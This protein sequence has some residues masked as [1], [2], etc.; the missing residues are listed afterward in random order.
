[1][2]PVMARGRSY[3][4]TTR[5]KKGRKG[6]TVK[7]RY[8]ISVPTP[9]MTGVEIR[10]PSLP[11]WHLS[12]KIL[13]F[14][15]AAGLAILLY[16]LLTHPLFQVQA[17]EVEGLLRLTPEEVSHSLD[18]A[19][20]PVFRLDP[21]QMKAALEEDYPE[22]RD[23]SILIGLPAQ[24]V[25][26][27][28]ER[29]PLIAWNQGEQ[30]TWVDGEGYAFSPRG[31]AGNL[32]VVNASGTP[33]VPEPLQAL[34]EESTEVLPETLAENAPEERV[35]MTP[36]FVNAVLL[37][38]AQ[39]PEKVDLAFDPVHGFGW[40]DARGWQVFFGLDVSQMDTKLRVYK[41]IVKKVKAEGITP[42]LIS[43]EHV[44]APYY[45]M[46]R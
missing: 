11:V 45:R 38:R 43:I 34:P 14:S 35:F 32:V 26:Q 6:K 8:D 3:P 40:Q 5:A 27:V 36:E 37:M 23:I 4:P 19:N 15:L 17:V 42:A 28:T 41:S 44:H 22:L 25:I 39:A 1:M 13:S 10:L 31:E 29:V 2:P 21:M 30:T 46:E 20:Q 9:G 16:T 12:W 7:R 24:V 33:P 18:I